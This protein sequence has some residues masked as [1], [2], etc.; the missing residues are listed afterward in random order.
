MNYKYNEKEII[1]NLMKMI[2]STYNQHYAGNEGIQV[3]DLLMDD[4][5]FFGFA[6]GNIVKYISRFGK[7]DG[8][9][10]DDLYKALHYTVL[11]VYYAEHYLTKGEQDDE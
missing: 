7:K 10:L 6:K 1:D 9:K 2:D 11:L 5:S 8:K 4:G 3:N